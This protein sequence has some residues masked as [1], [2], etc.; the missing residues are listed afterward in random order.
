MSKPEIKFKQVGQ[1]LT[2]IYRIPEKGKV[3]V[4][5]TTSIKDKDERDAFKSKSQELI[6]AIDKTSSDKVISSKTKALLKMF[7]AEGE[8]KRLEE[9][10]EK[11]KVKS[12]VKHAKKEAKVEISKNKKK[13]SLVVSTLDAIKS[14]SSKDQKA[15]SDQLATLGLIQNTVEKIPSTT[16]TIGTRYRGEH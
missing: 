7:N 12:I 14:M 1:N 2:L 5:Y 15:L 11:V 9:T 6:L 13:V 3:P 16:V 8:Q 10:T 4:K